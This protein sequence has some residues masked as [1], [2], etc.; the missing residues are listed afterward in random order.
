MSRTFPRALGLSPAKWVSLKVFMAGADGTKEIPS[1]EFVHSSAAQRPR[2]AVV[3]GNILKTFWKAVRRLENKEAC[4]SLLLLKTRNLWPRAASC[5]RS[6]CLLCFWRFVAFPTH[7]DDLGN[8]R[9]LHRDAVKDASRLHRFT[10]V[11]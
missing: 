9:L 4:D 3:G 10:V 11:R 7:A 8:A 6:A 5:C 1:T 2:Q